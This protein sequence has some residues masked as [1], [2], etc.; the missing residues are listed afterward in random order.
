M[1][2]RKG[3]Q[4][5]GETELLLED[6]EDLIEQASEEVH[7]LVDEGLGFFFAH[8]RG[9]FEH[10]L[11]GNFLLLGGNEIIVEVDSA[12]GI[13]SNIIRM[14]LDTQRIGHTLINLGPSQ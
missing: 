12:V 5:V 13:G 1:A 3:G 8:F 4:R 9:S 6:A 10:F 14:Q 11:H 7:D 2:A